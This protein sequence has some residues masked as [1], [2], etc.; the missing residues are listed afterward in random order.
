MTNTTKRII[1]SGGGT[2]GHIFPAI[3]IANELMSR[4]AGTEILFVGARDRMEMERVPAAG[5][6]IKGLPVAGF[7]RRLT[8]KNL[9]VIL[10]LLQSLLMAK[11]IIAEFKPHVAI[12]V[13]G[14]ASAPVLRS[15]ARKG[16]PTVI[17]EQNSYAGVTNKLLARKAKL[18]CVAYDN[19]ERY[20]PKE[21]IV[22]TGNP[23]RQ[24]ILEQ[25]DK[26]KAREFFHITHEKPVVLILGGSLG[27]R[28]INEA[29]LYHINELVNLDACIIWQTGK[30]YY[31]Q[32]REKA[33]S[34]LQDNI[35]IYDFISRMDFAYALSQ[36]IVSRA[37]AGTIS[38]IQAVGKACI[39]IP[40]PNVA[41]DHQTRNA[42]A[43]TDQ[44]AAIL[45]KD[46]EVRDKLIPQIKT[47][48]EN[49][50]QRDELAKN[51]GSM[52][53]PMAAQHIVNEIY[54]VLE[55]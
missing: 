40:S 14:Y 41:E 48:T 3:A 20:F 12:G 10:K 39:L 18:I 19:M 52:A 54:K 42:K 32:A 30:L 5:Y 4:D 1:I 33:E 6:R 26:N 35:K 53:R 27:A 24:D 49:K 25:I 45:I 15:A 29:V 13:G 36:V 22:I 50:V 34:H 37:G 17:Q 51:C 38:E 2:G 11:K 46:P 9:L 47:L 28:S 43:L 23:I 7:Q 55:W 44:N 16:I 21:K 8:G 31:Q